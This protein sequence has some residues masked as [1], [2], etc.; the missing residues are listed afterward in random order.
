[1]KNSALFIVG[2]ISTLAVITLLKVAPVVGP[3]FSLVAPVCAF[4]CYL[5][6]GATIYDVADELKGVSKILLIGLAIL[7]HFFIY[8]TPFVVGYFTFPVKVQRSVEKSRQ[9]QISYRKSFDLSQSMFVE[10]TGSSG[11]LG[12]AK[13]DMRQQLSAESVGEYVDKKLKHLDGLGSFISAVIN[14][15]LYVIPVFLKWLLADTLS[16]VEEP[17]YIGLGFW[18]LVGLFWSA[19]GYR[20]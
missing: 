2:I 9:V 18:Y 12:Y 4:F 5:L 1:M 7:L 19:V 20:M 15:I 13:Y 10:K 17:A 16:L 3:F 14:T 11:I 6:Y 8:I